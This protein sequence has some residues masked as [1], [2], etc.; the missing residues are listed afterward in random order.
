[1]K[2][3]LTILMFLAGALPAQL[4]FKRIALLPSGVNTEMCGRPV[5][6]DTDHNGLKEVIYATGSNYPG[7]PLRWEIWEY[8]PLNRFELVYADTGCDYPHPPGITSGNFHP[9][10][11]GDI[12]HDG[13]TDL[14]GSNRDWIQ[15]GSSFNELLATYESPTDTSYPRSLSWSFEWGP[16]PS[17]PTP[18]YLRN[19]LD[20]DTNR[21]LV[22]G[23]SDP[24]V[25]LGVWENVSDNQNEL[26][27]HSLT[28]PGNNAFGD[29]DGDGR[30]EFATGWYPVS[31]FKC[32]GDDNYQL[33]YQDTNTPGNGYDVF[34]GDVNGDGNPE[35][36]VGFW[37]YLSQRFDLYMWQA[38]GGVNA[39]QRVFVD[40]KSYVSSGTSMASKCGDID[41]DGVAEIV[42]ATPKYLYIYKMTGPDQ[43]QQIWQWQQD[44]G[45]EEGIFVTIADVN[46]DGYN[47]IIASGG[48]W[49]GSARTSIF[50]IEAVRVLQPNG[51]EAYLPGEDHYIKWQTFTPPRCD[52]L[53]VLF[54]PDNGRTLDLLAH[55]LPP[56]TDSILWHVPDVNSDSCKIRVIAYGPGAQA[57]ESDSVFSII[58]T[59]LSGNAGPPVYETKLLGAYPNPLTS[60]TSIRFQLSRQTQVSLRICDVTG[61]TVVTLTD[62]IMRPGV[63]HRDWEVAPT[64]PNGIYFIR[65]ETPDCRETQK[66]VLSR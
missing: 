2:R 16:H 37:T 27:W 28:A 4:Q 1:M 61:R 46:N 9:Y 34:S 45:S 12:D 20:G 39:Y 7:D 22:A 44:N 54:T 64:V 63:Y 42:W 53:S 40:Q 18:L 29:F 5:C 6:Y 50:E 24:S 10:D 15:P 19:D 23:V 38:T 35:F 41:G 25:G 57:D 11:V 32:V 48:G 56:S 52:S 8:R 31:V 49:N 58:S 60:A 33:V 14:A 17:E 13:L 26:V 51:G 21:E 66:V 59:G 36:F 30:N 47:E 3:T 62:G 55:G 43:F 65:L